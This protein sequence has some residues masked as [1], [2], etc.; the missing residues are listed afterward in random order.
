MSVHRQTPGSEIPHSDNGCKGH[1]TNSKAI[2]ST[3]S[4]SCQQTMISVIELS[5]VS[6]TKPSYAWC[7][8][9][10]IKKTQN[11]SGE[12]KS[13]QT[14]LQ[15]FTRHSCKLMSKVLI[16]LCFMPGT[17]TYA[18]YFHFVA[19]T[20]LTIVVYSAVYITTHFLGQQITT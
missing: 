13:Y 19:L 9:C 1:S 6:Y 2:P 17:P 20:T 12:D 8:Q 18:V 10:T 7:Q 16:I 14:I 3:M 11:C 5:T 15:F 4:T